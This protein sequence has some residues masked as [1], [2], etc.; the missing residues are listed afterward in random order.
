MKNFFHFFLD[1]SIWV[2][3]AVCG[4]TGLSFIYWDVSVDYVFI[5]FVFF[6]SIT[7]YNFV[8]FATRAGLHHRSLTRYLR[9]I[10]VFS[11]LCSAAFIYLFYRLPQGMQFVSIVFGI[12]TFLYTIPVFNKKSLRTLSGLKIFIVAWVWTGVTVVL[13]WLYSQSTW[14]WDDTVFLSQRFLWVLV[15]TLPFEIR[16]LKFDHPTLGTLPQLMGVSRTKMLGWFLLVSIAILGIFAKKAGNLFGYTE[17][18]FLGVLAVLLAFA[19]KDR[20]KYFAAFWV[21][22][23]PL[24]WLATYWLLDYLFSS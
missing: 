4:F 10:Q 22:G 12:F 9:A 21:E 18:F 1:S 14:T 7:G 17:I 3:L 20:A 2:S 24:F 11:F 6:G 8:K 5:A 16:D 15:L 13:P 19:T 23:I